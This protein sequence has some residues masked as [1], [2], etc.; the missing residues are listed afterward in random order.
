MCRFC[1]HKTDQKEGHV[2]KNGEVVR[3]PFITLNLSMTQ[4]PEGRRII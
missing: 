1:D 2:V 4:A 3:C